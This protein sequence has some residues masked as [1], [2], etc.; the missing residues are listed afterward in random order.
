MTFRT[1]LC[2]LLDIA[3]PIVQSGMGAIAGPDLVVEVCRAGGLG[4]L[5]GLNVPPDDLRKMIHRT[6]ELTNRPFGVNLWLHRALRPPIDPDAIREE[7]LRGAQ[8]MLNRFRQRLGIPTTMARPARAPDLVDAAIKVVLDERPPVFSAALGW[9]EP[10]LVD[11]C[12][13]RGIKVMAMVSTVEDARTAAAGGA[14]VIVAQGGE[15][16][17]H[18][19]IDG[20]PA[21]S[22]ATT[23]GIMALLPQVVDAVRVPVVAAGGIADGRGLVAALALGASGV[24][25]GT[26][27][28]ATRESMAPELYKKRVLESES[29]ATTVTDALSG[30]W[31]RALANRFTREYAESGAPVLPPLIQRS[32]ANDVYIAALRQG[33]AEYY[34]MMAGQSVGLVRDLPGAGEVVE[35]IIREARAVLSALPERIRQT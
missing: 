13:R 5:A 24:L 33:D 10:G 25:L 19:S 35:T 8:E 4:I 17:G 16:G 20:K 22:D 18:R 34:P 26:R 9:L 2:D 3:Y 27:F 30:L 12:H 29:D 1:T 23:V 6:R 28:V 21:A 31:A 7:T 32:A 11:D 14:D 15:A